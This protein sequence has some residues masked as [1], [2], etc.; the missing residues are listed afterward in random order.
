MFTA[1]PQKHLRNAK[2]YFQAHLAQGDYYSEGKKIQVHWL[3]AGVLRL[4]LDPMQAV[5]T[6][7][8][9]R[10]CDNLH[11][12][13]GKRL[14]VRNRQ[15]NHRVY[16]DFAASAPKSVSIM[17]ETVGDSRVVVAHSE[18]ARE[19]AVEMQKFA[20]TRIRQGGQR[21]E[22]ITGEIVAAV[23]RHET[24][25][26]LDPHLH[27]H[28]VVF[29]AT[30]DAVEGRWKAL[31]TKF[32]F[33]CMNYFTEV[34]RN[35]LARRLRAL[36]YSIRNTANGFEIADVPQTI[37][38]RYS[39]RRR[40]ILTA[41][42]DAVAA[43][44]KKLREELEQAVADNVGKSTSEHEK[45]ERALRDFKPVTSLSNNGRATLAHTTRQWKDNSLDPADVLAY[46]RSQLTDAEMGELTKLVGRQP[47]QPD[48][49]NETISAR[50]AIDYAKEHIFERS[51]VVHYTQLLQVAL[52]FSRGRISKE[53][54]EIELAGRSDFI[55]VNELLTTR[56]TLEQERRMIAIANHGV[57]RFGP[58][59]RHFK[60]KHGLTDEQRKAVQFILHS[61]DQFIGLRGAAGTG[62]THLLQ[63][64]LRG[65]EERHE[66]VIL[67]PTT[68]SVEELRK[69]GL[70]NAATL[71]R[72]LSDDAFQ[73][74][75]A[76]KVV[77]VDEAGLLSR[78]DMLSLMAIAA[79]SGSRVIFSGDTRQ[80]ASV[81]AGDALRLLENQSG[82]RVVGVKTI[83]RQ[84]NREYRQA[85]AELA[86]GQ[87][88][89]AL[90]RLER[91]GAVEEIEGDERYRRLAG[92]YLASVKAGKTALVVSPTWRE[93]N[94][95]TTAIR[96]GLK[97][98]GTLGQSDQKITVHHSLKWTK[99]QKRDLRNYRAGMVLSFFR[100]TSHFAAGDS[101][102]V[103]A[104]RDDSVIV[105][106]PGKQALAITKK[107]AACFD[108]LEKRGLAVASGELLLLQ[109]SRKS[110]K[111]FNGQ[112]VT[113]R[114]V[115][116]DGSILLA[117]GRTI[118]S[119]FRTFTHGYCMTSPASQGRTVDHVFVAMD[120]LS[121]Q[122]TNRNQF[123][124]S[125][126]RASE[127]VR[128]FTDDKE[129]LQ[130]V[131]NRPGDRLS[132]L[133]LV[134][135]ARRA[136]RESIKQQPA[137]KVSPGI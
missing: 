8:F 130:M 40:A 19:A 81:E 57:D 38:D 21:G 28:F 66:T 85:I 65:I 54:L 106:G 125:T 89:K 79:T 41:E 51:S 1:K 123:Y 82:L 20:A 93:V 118:P 22:R 9:E 110:A 63:E 80:H 129:F 119:E 44:N 126:S 74:D 55:A 12:V 31:E 104:V 37:I 32:M 56:E 112:I 25:R 43:I 121:F 13:T 61:T 97:Q 102:E 30:W 114:S 120:S 134:E 115:N 132:A 75:A 117:D 83:R 128:I 109:A 91:L 136:K 71:Q 59:N 14:T 46:Q 76:G 16:Y 90:A 33:E 18:S 45:A 7:Q 35:S 94:Q 15:K 23:V 50:Q 68:A 77:V 122:A 4:G 17:A 108:V 27:T 133:E 62:K 103:V 88:L 78:Q 99:A 72:F 135:S 96:E 86:D 105:S 98:K 113:A 60:S 48:S 6:A 70:N 47:V 137:I 116:P 64:L 5:T 87:G 107:Q 29:N 101:V 92:E 95:V 131:V 36:G 52:A 53:G 124:V 67:S 26:A 10:L 24:S 42:T 2:E 3:G 84:V 69:H 100:R 127:Q 58:L 11:P 34:Y 49:I 73:N 111:V 39:K